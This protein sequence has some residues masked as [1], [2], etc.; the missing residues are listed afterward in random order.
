MTKFTR[1]EEEAIY[2]AYQ[3]A[4]TRRTKPVLMVFGVIALG[5]VIYGVLL[6]GPLVG[7]GA[8]ALAL[9]AVIIAAPIALIMLLMAVVV[10]P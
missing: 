5:V 4:A 7:A 1:E 2:R 9:P 6:P 8:S 3:R 10:K